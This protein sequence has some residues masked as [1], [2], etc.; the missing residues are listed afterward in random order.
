[1]LIFFSVDFFR[2]HFHLSYFQ[3]TIM[4]KRDDWRL[5]DDIIGGMIH[6]ETGELFNFSDGVGRISKEYADRIAKA[7]DLHLTPSCYQV[8]NQP[9]YIL[10][11][12]L[13]CY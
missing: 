11:N 5:E 1:M 7:L 2:Q 8:S 10:V 9:I 6:P 12:V 4:L 3:P 13:N